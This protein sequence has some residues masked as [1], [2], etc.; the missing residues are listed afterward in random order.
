MKLDLRALLIP[1]LL[2]GAC[3]EAG[4]DADV[5]EAAPL[6]APQTVVDELLAADRAFATAAADTTGV[7]G[8]AAMFADDVIMTVPGR[9]AEGKASAIE[10][11]A[12]SPGAEGSTVSWTP[13]RGG[14]SADG[15]HGFT[16]GYMT[17]RRADSTEVPMKYL[18]YWIKQPA[19]WRVAAFKRR[20]RPEGEV[21]LDLMPPVL[22]PAMV[23]PS[24]DAAATQA[25][26]ESLRAAEQAFSDEAQR[27]GNGI[28]FTRHGSPDAMNLGGPDDIGFVI[29]ADSIGAGM[30]LDSVPSEVNWSA[31][32]VIVASSGDLGVTF[33]MIRL[34]TPPADTTQPSQ[35]P[36]FTIWRRNSTNDPWK[37]VAE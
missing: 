32:R 33:G 22:P 12:S 3:A 36:F 17:V 23:Q 26:G 8:V 21:S 1:I 35:F 31:D 2:A 7:E 13:V 29:S 15:Q 10:A 16:Y 24:T 19:G 9:F 5:P 25:F 14:I 28:A 34:N 11:M 18:S 6:P 37:Y 27:T 30:S 4:S 20:P